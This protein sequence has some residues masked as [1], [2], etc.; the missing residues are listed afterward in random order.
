MRLVHDHADTLP[1][2]V[3]QRS[4]KVSS[5]PWVGAANRGCQPSDTVQAERDKRSRMRALWHR[6]LPT[7]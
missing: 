3:M 4:L 7:N 5:V 6:L 2:A 1:T